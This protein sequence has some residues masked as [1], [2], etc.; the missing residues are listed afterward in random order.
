MKSLIIIAASAVALGAAV[1]AMAQTA[2]SW[3]PDW[4]HPTYYGSIGDSYLSTNHNGGIDEITGRV[5]A[6]FGEHWGVEG[7]IGGGLSEGKT[8]H[9]PSNVYTTEPLA[10]AGYV[11]GYLPVAPNLEFLARVGYGEDN[12]QQTVRNVQYNGGTHSANFGV[13]AQYWLNP[14][15]AVRIDYTRRDYLGGSQSPIGA[16][17]FALSY[18]RKF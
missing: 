6:R 8:S 3:V 11:V 16:D 1:P 15:D 12:F 17:A 14:A 9:G 10:G 5:G 2:D 18:V 13:G 4:S 7:E